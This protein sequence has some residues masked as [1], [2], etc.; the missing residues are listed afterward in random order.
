ML[1]A[2]KVSQRSTL[3]RRVDAP[4]AQARRARPRGLAGAGRAGAAGDLDLVD[5][6]RQPHARRRERAPNRVRVR[7]HGQDQRGR[8]VG[9]VPRH[10]QRRAGPLPAHPRDAGRG[11]GAGVRQ[12][13][14][15]RAG[16]AAARVLP[17]HR[18]RL[19]RRGPGAVRPH[20]R[21]AGG[22]LRAR[23]A[24]PRADLPHLPG[25]PATLAFAAPAVWLLLASRRFERRWWALAAGVV[26]GLGML[27]K[28]NFAFVWPGLV[29]VML[30]RGGWRQWRHV[31]LFV[32]ALAVVA[33]P[34]YLSHTGDLRSQLEFY[35]ASSVS[36]Y[37]PDLGTLKQYS[38]R[39]L[40]YYP[41][42]LMEVDVYLPLLVLFAAGALYSI[43]RLVGAGA[44][45]TTT[46]RSSSGGCWSSG[47][48]CSTSTRPT[49][50]LPWRAWSTWRCSAPDGW[51]IC[52]DR[53]CWPAVSCSACSSCS[54]TLTNFGL[55]KKVSVAGGRRLGHGGVGAGDRRQQAARHLAA[56]GRAARPAEAGVQ[57]PYYVRPQRV[58]ARLRARRRGHHGQH[59]RHDLHQPAPAPRRHGRDPLSGPAPGSTRPRARGSPTASS[60]AVGSTSCVG[61]RRR[62]PV[63]G[64]HVRRAP[65]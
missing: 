28:T 42:A 55:G 57:A 52:R 45:A 37:T 59:R 8:P 7:L 12:E 30:I 5:R 47:S 22:G 17:A 50:A 20:R 9:L 33:L 62:K 25:R 16:R 4:V 10:P 60:A 13:H 54:T 21:R 51:S 14:Q 34:W 61:R 27:T 48:A 11:V 31:L 35:G 64:R 53:R 41:R 36:T 32:A 29:A 2:G 65:L 3:A 46:R 18:R 43:G 26:V 56:A 49:G 6:D 58:P 63:A 15:R 1:A 38:L 44:T 23:R 40:S 39:H 19:L 24:R